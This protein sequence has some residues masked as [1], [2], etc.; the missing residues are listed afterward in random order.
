MTHPVPTEGR[1]GTAGPKVPKA[2]SCYADPYS[3]PPRDCGAP[4][5]GCNPAWTDCIEML[6]EC[7]W[8]GPDELRA[9]LDLLAACKQAE[10]LIRG[11]GVIPIEGV[12][13]QMLRAA[14]AQVEGR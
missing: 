9:A 2:R 11:G 4:F 5:C 7:G 12:T 6:L 13:W 14:I 10:K 3:D 1:E 8:K